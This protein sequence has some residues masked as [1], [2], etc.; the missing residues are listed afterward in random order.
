MVVYDVMNK[1]ILG[2]EERNSVGYLST[3]RGFRLADNIYMVS[4]TF[5]KMYI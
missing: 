4:H 5:N 1:M 3:T 2:K